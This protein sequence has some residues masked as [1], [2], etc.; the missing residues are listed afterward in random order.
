MKM[1]HHEARAAYTRYTLGASERGEKPEH[2]DIFEWGH[3]HGV[4]LTSCESPNHEYP[5]CKGEPWECPKCGRLLCMQEG[6]GDSELCDSCL[7]AEPTLDAIT[8]R[9]YAASDGGYL[10]DVYT[11]DAVDED[12]ADNSDDG[13][14]CTGAFT[15]ALGMAES[16]A[17][18]VLARYT[19]KKD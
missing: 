5:Y 19:P 18:D 3:A 11:G 13:G 1:N 9:I 12:L 4:E 14:L 17:R 2:A 8:I 10:Y 15:D 7:A 6:G 16:A